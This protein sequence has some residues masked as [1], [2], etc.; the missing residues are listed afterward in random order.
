M[1]Y[2][3]KDEVI[4]RRKIYFQVRNNGRVISRKVGE[5]MGQKDNVR[6]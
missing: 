5:N 3:R 4:V 1:Y 6:L 2:L